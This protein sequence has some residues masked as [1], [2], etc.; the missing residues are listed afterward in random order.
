AQL[1]LRSKDGRDARRQD[2]RGVRG[3]FVTGE[4]KRRKRSDSSCRSEGGPGIVNGY[5]HVANSLWGECEGW[6]EWCVRGDVVVV[7]VVVGYRESAER[8]SNGSVG[9][10]AGLPGKSDARADA[11]VLIG[12]GTGRNPS[13]PGIHQARGRV[14]VDRALVARPPVGCPPRRS[15]RWSPPRLISKTEFQSQ[16]RLQTNRVVRERNNFGRRVDV[17][18]SPSLLEIP[19]IAEHEIREE[20]AGYRSVEVYQRI[21]QPGR[22]L[23]RVFVHDAD[24][25]HNHVLPLSPSNLVADVPVVAFLDDVLLKPGKARTSPAH[26]DRSIMW[27]WLWDVGS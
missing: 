19:E 8:R 25:R 6:T 1:E 21:R 27:V 18:F 10:E 12:I 26:K 3:G 2:E 16:I 4:G 17:V 23:Q 11:T 15:R 22:L 24:T 13:I 20:A 7:R 5:P 14:R 9:H